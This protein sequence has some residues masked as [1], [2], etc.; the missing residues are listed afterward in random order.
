MYGGILMTEHERTVNDK[1]IQAYR[2][3]DPDQ[4]QNGV[5]KSGLDQI[6]HSYGQIQKKYIHR[7]FS[8]G[9]GSTAGLAISQSTNNLV[10][11]GQGLQ[12]EYQQ[13]QRF[14]QRMRDGSN[15]TPNPVT[16]SQKNLPT[17]NSLANAGNNLIQSSVSPMKVQQP[18]ALVDAARQNME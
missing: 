8:R 12:G 2:N 6:G 1:A 3:Q 10:T 18:D 7:A 9:D 14:A 4:A 17:M 11:A 15:L 5:S 16:A 13:N